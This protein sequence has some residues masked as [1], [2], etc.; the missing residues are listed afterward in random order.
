MF[1]VPYSEIRTRGAGLAQAGPP[2]FVDGVRVAVKTSGL[3]QA[4]KMIEDEDEDDDEDERLAQGI[5][6]LG[7]G[8]W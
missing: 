8:R 7:G 4:V 2:W 6:S 1:S 5:G 3:R